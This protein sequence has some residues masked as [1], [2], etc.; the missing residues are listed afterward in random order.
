MIEPGGGIV[1]VSERRK[2]TLWTP[3]SKW[4]LAA[5]EVIK[6]HLGEQRRAGSGYFKVSEKR[7][8][9]FIRE[10][11]FKKF[12]IYRQ[13]VRNQWDMKGALGFFYSMSFSSK[14]VLGKSVR[15]FERDMKRELLKA[16]PSGRFT[17]N[18]VLE[19]LIVKRK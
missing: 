13:N 1:I 12:E 18:T 15:A 4:R 16:N 9:D 8:E 19:A 6:K 7:F 17:E 10:S 2:D 11:P 14:A 5:S 3:S